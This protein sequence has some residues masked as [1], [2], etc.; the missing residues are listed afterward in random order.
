MQ[1]MRDHISFAAWYRSPDM[2]RHFAKQVI[3]APCGN[4]HCTVQAMQFQCRGIVI[5]SGVPH[6]LFTEAESACNHCNC[7]N[8]R[9][10]FDTFMN[11]ILQMKSDNRI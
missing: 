9:L 2:H 4:L 5:Q 1:F 6:T 10:T 8:V 11:W 3:L 7:G